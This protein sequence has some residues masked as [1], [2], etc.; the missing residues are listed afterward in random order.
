MKTTKD[1]LKEKIWEYEQDPKEA[2]ENILATT[3]EVM[4]QYKNNPKSKSAKGVFDAC[5]EHN[6]LFLIEIG[7]IDI[8]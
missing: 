6:K 1:W 2:L 4:L 3:N 5:I 8:V 7:V